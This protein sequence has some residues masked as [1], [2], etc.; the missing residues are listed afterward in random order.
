[1]DGYALELGRFAAAAGH[2]MGAARMKIAASRWCDRAGNLPADRLECCAAIFDAGYLRQQRLGVWV[3]RVGEQFI[4]RRGFHDAAQV[5]DRYAIAQMADHT[6]VVADEEVGQVQLIAQIHEQIQ[7]LCLDRDIQ[8][9][10]GFIAD[11]QPGL[12]GQGACDTDALALPAAELMRVA[13]TQARIQAGAF[14]LGTDVVI[15]VRGIHQAM[16]SRRFS[17]DAVDTQPRVQTGLRILEDHL[18]TQ[19]CLQRL[20]GIVLATL[21]AKDRH[22]AFG[23]R[24]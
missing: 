17:N 15:L 14:E 1:M 16:Q 13:E 2:G 6:Q 7:N 11:E 10:D 8:R 9:G 23:R 4:D 3:P 24:L 20:V 19:A 21:L 5:H 22:L 18:H 12:H